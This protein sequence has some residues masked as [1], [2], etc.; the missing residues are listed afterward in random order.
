MVKRSLGQAW[1]FASENSFLAKKISGASD[2]PDPL[3]LYS[4]HAVI[5][6]E[7]PI[8]NR[9]RPPF[10]PFLAR[11]MRYGVTGQEEPYEFWISVLS[12]F[13]GRGGLVEYYSDTHRKVRLTQYG[14]HMFPILMDVFEA[15]YR[16]NDRLEEVVESYK[17]SLKPDK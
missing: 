9:I 17:S 15:L 8:C 12:Q 3:S 1:P 4:L 6:K 2:F 11:T 10:V 14:E 7:E 16:Q 5:I 13:L